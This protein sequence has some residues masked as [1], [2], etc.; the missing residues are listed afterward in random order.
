M[1]SGNPE[2]KRIYGKHRGPIM[3][4]SRQLARRGRTVAK[5]SSTVSDPS[6][7]KKF[8]AWSVCPFA[9]KQML[10]KGSFQA[11][12]AYAVT[13]ATAQVVS[14]IQTVLRSVPNNVIKH[15]RADG[16]MKS[17]AVQHSGPW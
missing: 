13:S 8:V 3:A 7:C 11:T 10:L 4:G 9:V 1:A 6:E 15:G 14:V 2:A 16:Q 5:V 12:A 17:G